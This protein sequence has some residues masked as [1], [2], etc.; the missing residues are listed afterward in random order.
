[1]M[2][3]WSR[4]CISVS[5]FE[6]HILLINKNN[7][8]KHN[9][10]H[11]RY[12]NKSRSFSAQQVPFQVLPELLRIQWFP[13]RFYL[14]FDWLNFQKGATI[15][16]RRTQVQ[17]TT[18][19]FSQ[20]DQEFA[21]VTFLLLPVLYQQQGDNNYRSFSFVPAPQS[22][23]FLAFKCRNQTICRFPPSRKMAQRM[24]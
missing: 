22:V 21:Q 14:W 24:Y 6:Q 11:C 16:S 9:F 5:S 2:M 8:V 4:S 19:P 20:S 3:L 1:M 10:H 17:F 15:F 7:T 23:F 13:S 18:V 12:L